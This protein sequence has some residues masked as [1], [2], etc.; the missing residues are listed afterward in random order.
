MLTNSLFPEPHNLI[1]TLPNTKGVEEEESLPKDSKIKNAVKG[2]AG[3]AYEFASS[4]KDKLDN[5]T[6][7]QASS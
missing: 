6:E 2:A 5:C 3:K 4:V 1:I 7:S